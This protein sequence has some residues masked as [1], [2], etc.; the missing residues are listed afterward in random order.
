[1]KPNHVADPN[2]GENDSPENMNKSTYWLVAATLATGTLTSPLRAESDSA[3]DSVSLLRQQI[4][5]LDQKIRILERKDELN[6]EEKEKKRVES[7]KVTIGD[8]GFQFESADKNFSLRLRGLLQVDNRSFI[9]NGHNATGNDSFVLRR[10]RP[11]IQGKVYNNYEYTFLPEF[12]GGSNGTSSAFSILD[13]NLNVNY[14]KEFQVKAGKFKAPVGLE[15]LQSDPNRTFVETS[16]ATNLV[17]NRDIGVQVHGELFDGIIA[18]QGGVF[19]GSPDGT[20]AQNIDFDNNREVAARVILTPFKSTSINELKGFSFG[21]AATEGNKN[22]TTTN[23]GVT[24][25]YLT[26][27]QQTF[28][29]YRNASTTTLKVAGGVGSTVT[30]TTNNNITVGDGEQWRIAPQGTYYYGP[31]S[32]QGEYVVSNQALRKVA[33]GSFAAGND[34]RGRVQN[35]AWSLAATYVLT[36]ED[37]SYT[38]VTPRNNFSLSNGNWGAFEVAARYGELDI[39]G[40][41]FSGGTASFADATT[42]ATGASSV[43]LGLNWYL[44][45]NVRV[46]TDYFT[47]NFKGGSQ[48]TGLTAQDEHVIISR[49]QL[50]Y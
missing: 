41:A 39:N 24:S 21:V 50:F 46:T 43:G 1:M 34:R 47:T 14:W 9:D 15:Q 35:E 19:D 22:G 44:N 26:E 23:R 5:A 20:N 37:A 48:A 33:S 10:V 12:G 13:A 28:F 45:K 27:G 2:S 40:S 25:G 11:I 42:Q 17:P 6:E 4:E 7:P 8:K 38:G 49:L 29:A 31:F 32:L 3:V 18:Y 36:G 16:L 30:S